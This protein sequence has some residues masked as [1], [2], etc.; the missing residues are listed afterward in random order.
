MFSGGRTPTYYSYLSPG[1]GATPQTLKRAGDSVARLKRS[2]W[3]KGAPWYNMVPRADNLPQKRSKC[4]TK[5]VLIAL[6]L[7]VLGGVYG[8]LLLV[9]SGVLKAGC[10]G[11]APALEYKYY[12]HYLGSSYV[13]LIR[14]LARWTTTVCTREAEWWHNFTRVNSL[15]GASAFHRTL[16]MY[17]V[18]E[19]LCNHNSFSVRLCLVLLFS[20][21]LCLDRWAKTK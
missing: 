9:L 15:Q 4:T 10:L 17:A 11:A 18:C 1:D 2:T 14:I 20:F 16:W 6:Y 12:L 5:T 21:Y 7:F 8:S 3:L 19:P 13:G